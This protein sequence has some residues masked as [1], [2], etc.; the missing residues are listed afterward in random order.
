MCA[1]VLDVEG[2]TYVLYICTYIC[3]YMCVCSFYG[4][5]RMYVFTVCA[6]DRDAPLDVC[7]H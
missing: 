4:D 7:W 1:A 5:V 2:P 3:M 6:E